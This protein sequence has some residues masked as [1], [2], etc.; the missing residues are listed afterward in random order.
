MPVLSNLRETEEVA[1]PISG[2]KVQ[3]YTWLTAGEDAR[4]ERAYTEG[5]TAKVNP[6]SRE[7]SDISFEF[8]DF[9]KARELTLL[10]MIASWDF[11]DEKGKALTTSAANV[12]MLP[13]P[14]YDLLANH[15]DAIIAKHKMTEDEKK[16]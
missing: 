7:V 4:I 15:A 3:L 8:D 2:G 16:G 5:R 12:K 11:V 9:Y 10:L 13:Q 1:L 6:M 14:D